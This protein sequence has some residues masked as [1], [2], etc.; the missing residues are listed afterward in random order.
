MSGKIFTRPIAGTALLVLFGAS[1]SVFAQTVGVSRTRIHDPEAEAEN[2]AGAGLGN[3]L[4]NLIS[5]IFKS[6]SD[7]PFCPNLTGPDAA[8]AA[9]GKGPF[10]DPGAPLT[11]AMRLALVDNLTAAENTLNNALN[12]INNAGNPMSP[13]QQQRTIKSMNN[14]IN[15]I[16]GVLNSGVQAPRN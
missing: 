2:E 16:N 6:P 8:R 13:E 12:G 14:R 5:R 11:D 10:A 7:E 9:L 15:A 4:R 3:F 1:A